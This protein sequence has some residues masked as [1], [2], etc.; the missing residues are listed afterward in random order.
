MKLYKNWSLWYWIIIFAYWFFYQIP[1]SN[2]FTPST[3]GVPNSA[4]FVLYAIS[5]II[6]AFYIWFIIKIILS[7]LK[8][9]KTQQNKVNYSILLV[10]V[11]LSSVL[12]AWYV[13]KLF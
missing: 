6:P 3:L 12:I 1:L 10:C 5:D 2:T 9:I 11:I 4:D 7:I 8:K 13:F